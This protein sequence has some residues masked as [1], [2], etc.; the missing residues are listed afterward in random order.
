MKYAHLRDAVITDPL[1]GLVD[2]P[3]VKRNHWSFTGHAK[4]MRM[5]DI[6]IVRVDGVDL[7]RDIPKFICVC[8]LLDA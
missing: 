7:K 8:G 5:A 4:S 6:L 3:V 1:G 2:G